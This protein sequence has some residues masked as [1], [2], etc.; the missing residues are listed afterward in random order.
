MTGSSGASR[1]EEDRPL[2][3]S[4]DEHELDMVNIKVIE[5]IDRD[6]FN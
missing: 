3:F 4:I 1:A 5:Q 6:F 2:L